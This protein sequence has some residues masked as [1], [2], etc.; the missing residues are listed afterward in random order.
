M[1]LRFIQF[2]H[3]AL[4][5][6][7]GE[8]A[9]GVW[10]DG[11]HPFAAMLDLLGVVVVLGRIVLTPQYRPLNHLDSRFWGSAFNRSHFPKYWWGAESS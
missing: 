5:T 7:R 6:K 9:A 4:P 3:F 10:W 11:S 8:H 2:T 1:S